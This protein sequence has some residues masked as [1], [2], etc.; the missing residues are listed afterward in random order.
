MN[1]GKYIVFE[2][3]N[4]VEFPILFPAFIQHSDISK[5]IKQ[6]FQSNPISAGQFEIIHRRNGIAVAAYGNSLTLNI[7]SRGKVDSSLIEKV[8]CD[9]NDISP[10]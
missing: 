9:P 10:G 1:R 3:R 5:A 4:G 2:T 6:Q 8:V 7:S